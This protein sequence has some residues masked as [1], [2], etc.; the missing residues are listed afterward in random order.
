MAQYDLH[1]TQNTHASLIEFTERKVN[2]SKGGLISVDASHVPTVLPVGADTYMLVADSSTTTGLKWQAVAGGH[3]QNTDTGTT[4]SSFNISSGSNPIWLTNAGGTYPKLQIRYDANAALT[5]FEAREATFDKVTVVNAPGSGNELCNKTYVDGL[6][7]AN[8]AMVFK[9]TIGTGGTHTIAAFNALTTYNAGWTYRVIEAGTIRGVT[10]EIGDLVTVLVDRAGSGNANSDFTVVQTN[11]D[12]AVIGPASTTDNYLVLF[13]GTTGKLIKAGTG[14]PGTMAYET[15]TN[16][17][18]KSLLT[19]QGDIIYASAASTPAA[20]PHGNAGQ[21]LQSGGHGANPSWL[22]LGTM[23]AETATNYVLKSLFDA[24]TILYA[25]TD[26]TPA[27]LTVG[28]STIVGRKSTGG[29]V[30]LTPAEAMGVLFVGAPANN[31]AAG[32]AGQIA[33]D[34]NFL[35]LCTYTGTAGSAKWARATLATVWP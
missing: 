16:Y 17:M 9:G 20:L 30:A 7:A 35:Y 6:L 24:Y 18:A 31:T 23:A 15:A 3:T 32:T 2:L 4:Q 27:A 33:W 28:A 5:D 22:T 14:A 13:S 25:D 11:L 34:S 21:V 8:D 10:C 29:I 1:L 26:N 12:G 19:E